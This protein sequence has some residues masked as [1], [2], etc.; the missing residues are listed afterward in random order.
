MQDPLHTGFSTLRHAIFSGTGYGLDA[1]G[2]VAT[3]A[4]LERPALC[5]HH[6]LHF[7]AANITLAI[8]GDFDPAATLELLSEKF[9]ALPQGQPWVAPVSQLATGGELLRNLPKKQAVITIGFPGTSVSGA[10]R[11]ALAMIQ[12]YSS[13][14]AGPLFTRIREELGLAYQVGAT[15]FLGYDAGLFTFYVATSPE[16]AELARRELLAEIAKIAAHGIPDEAFDRVR[17]TV[18]SGLAIQQQSPASVARHV[19]LDLLFGHPA[20][21]HRLLPAAYQ[22]LTAE[23]VR[24]TAARIFS[25]KPTVITVLPE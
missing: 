24:H 3:L 15:Q 20:D 8:S 17:S 18:L 23:Q 25:V 10:D 19:A 6:A 11:H 7:N 22:A 2:S 4:A 16:Q 21:Q 5:A 9:A 12:E 1:L 13:D 14:M